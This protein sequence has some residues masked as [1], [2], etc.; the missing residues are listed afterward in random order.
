MGDSLPA[1]KDAAGKRAVGLGKSKEEL[2]WSVY[3]IILN[4]R[5]LWVP[6]A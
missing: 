6:E 1:G 2:S 3:N 5:F 4:P